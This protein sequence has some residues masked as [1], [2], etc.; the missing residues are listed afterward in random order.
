[1][2]RPIIL[3]VDDEK[4][5]CE[6]VASGLGKRGYDSDF[7]TDG[8]QALEALREKDYDAV[9]TDLN[10]GEMHGLELCKQVVANRPETPVI[11]ITA[12]GDMKTAIAALR[13]G[14]HDFIN[15]PIEMEFL[16]RAVRRAIDD[17][18]L[19]QEVTRLRQEV[20]RHRPVGDLIG[21]STP[22]KR[23]YDL[24]RRVSETDA[25]VFITGES[26]TGKE[27]IARAIHERGDRASRPF[28]AI[29]CAAVPANLL[30]SELFGHVRGAFTDAR[31][32]RKGLLA[33]ANGGTLLL[34]EVGEMPLEMQPKL[35][36]VLQ[37]QEFRP[38]GGDR[39]VSV[40][41]RIIAA[42][43]RDPEGDVEEGR[44][45]EDLYY[46]LNVVEI[47]VPP[48]RAR[49]NDILLLA[50]RFVRRVA[51]RLDKPVRGISKEAA[52]RLL[53]YDWPG[54]VRELENC[55]E[56]AVTLTAFD[57]IIVDDL[58]ERIRTFESK[59]VVLIDRDIEHLLTLEELE[60]RYIERV[61]ATVDDN[62]SAAARILGVDRRTLYRKLERYENRSG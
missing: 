52:R 18:D 37:E 10:L 58:P 1:M 42:T 4:S 29:N 38:V 15:K 54:N 39:S 45:R 3:I 57:Q 50:Q 44:F 33:E 12:F 20:D 40:D 9:V 53:E 13:A 34:D 56:R 5:M 61:L 47:H 27:L 49:G 17:R 51:K 22:M 30:E 60:R 43:N 59:R 6:L 23:V 36:R 8:A 28:V 55:V 35:L 48:L 41:V 19:L 2:T 21:E 14:A 31:T 32:A 24:I 26:G 25:S 46:R 11:V 62:K 16:A 7:R